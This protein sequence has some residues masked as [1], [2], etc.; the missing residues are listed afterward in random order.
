MEKG[1]S[2]AP[3]TLDDDSSHS[4]TLIPNKLFTSITQQ[5]KDTNDVHECAEAIVGDT[6]LEKMKNKTLSLRKQRRKG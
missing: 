2:N 4:D 1:R 5:H 6:H 3:P